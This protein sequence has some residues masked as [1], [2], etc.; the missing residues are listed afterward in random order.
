MSTLTVKELAAPTGFDL[1]IASGETLDLKS[2]GTVTMPTGSVLQVVENTY[3]TASQTGGSNFADTGLNAS[4]TPSA[5]SSKVLAMVYQPMSVKTDTSSARDVSYN[6]VR[7]STEIA[8][9]AHDMKSDSG[10]ETRKPV[11]NALIK[12][13]SPNTTSSVTYKTQF[14]VNAGS[15][16]VYAQQHGSSAT[17]ILIEIAG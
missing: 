4:I 1:K 17:M 12:L 6:L 9:G 14:K 13:D 10:T 11:T 2:Q 3:A 8:K 7:G 16:D 5:T 15:S